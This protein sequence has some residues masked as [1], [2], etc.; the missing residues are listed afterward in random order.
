MKYIYITRFIT[1]NQTM[2]TCDSKPEN[3]KV[4]EV[5]EKFKLSF[6]WSYLGNNR[7]HDYITWSAFQEYKLGLKNKNNS[8]FARIAVA[9]SKKS[10]CEVQAGCIIVNKEIYDNPAHCRDSNHIYDA[11]VMNQVVCTGYNR[12]TPGMQHNSLTRD[13][14]YLSIISA[15]ESA[16][17]SAAHSGTRLMGTTAYLTHYPSLESY[18]ILKLAG[19]DNIFYIWCTWD[20]VIHKTSWEE[21]HEKLLKNDGSVGLFDD[22]VDFICSHCPSHKYRLSQIKLIDD[23][24][25][26]NTETDVISLQEQ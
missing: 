25:Q 4:K 12:F 14:K 7:V 10:P 21:N 24:Q 1:T 9:V 6:T 19:I 20:P 26:L 5:K 8:D 15:E 23:C 11:N 22:A 3:E 13:N 18:K 17:A 2:G 16:V